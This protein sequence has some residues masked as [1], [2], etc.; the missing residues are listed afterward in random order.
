MCVRAKRVQTSWMLQPFR[1]A[2]SISNVNEAALTYVI[3]VQ[4]SQFLCRPLEPIIIPK[5][6]WM[7]EA[8][9]Y[10]TNSSKYYRNPA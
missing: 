4:R 8:S 1:S 9:T 2:V 7:A 6:L 10:A 5:L 3:S